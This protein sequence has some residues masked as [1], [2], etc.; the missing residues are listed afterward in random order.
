MAELIANTNAEQ[1]ILKYLQENLPGLITKAEESGKNISDCL[2]WIMSQFKSKAQNG[3]AAA[4]SEEVFGM[5]VH[6]FQ[7]DDIK[8][9]SGGRSAYVAT[10]KPKVETV[11]APQR[12]P[13]PKKVEKPKPVQK[14]NE[15]EGQLSLF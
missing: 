15:M 14:T 2:N 13:E 11:K 1:K 12:D 6:Y 7:E 5:A 9:Y 3:C 8:K 10:A 4:T